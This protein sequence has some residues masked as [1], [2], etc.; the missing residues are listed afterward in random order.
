MK[1]A[2]FDYVRPQTLADAAAALREEGVATAAIAGGQ[3]LMPMLNLR[4]VM[5]DR[6]VDISRLEELQTVEATPE[7]LRIGALTTHAAIEDGKV[8]DLHNGLLRRVAWQ[9][10]YRAVRNHGTIGG[11][12]ALADP[13]ADWPACLIALDAE[14]RI[15]GRDGER[16]EPVAAFV[17]DAYATSLAAGEIVLGFDLP[18]PDRPLRWGFAKV[19]PKSGAF[20]TSIAV[21]T[22]SLDGGPVSVVLSAVA[23]RPFALVEVAERLRDPASSEDTLRSAIAADMEAQVPNTD[24]YQ[25]RLHTATIL[26]AAREMRAQ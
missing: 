18:R 6:I 4:A 19:A 22:A 7:C 10:S 25:R 14:V 20:A 3:S 11:S 2:A 9:I 21:I 8:P 15:A 17:R 12:V 5:V 23:S 1:P 26:R 24:A 16:R 13:S